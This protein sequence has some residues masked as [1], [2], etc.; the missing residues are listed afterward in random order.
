[1]TNTGDTALFDISVDDDTIGHIGNIASLGVGQTTELTAEI[2]LGS[3]PITNIATAAGS[4][5]LGLSV[6]DVDEAT[7]TVVAG[8]GG[9]DDDGTDGTGGSPFTGRDLDGLL[10]WVLGLL[11]LGAALLIASR[12]RVE[13]H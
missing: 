10:G 8:G 9:G 6:S 5:V 7:V 13:G 11:V 2:T 3:S 4:D 1:M 12:R